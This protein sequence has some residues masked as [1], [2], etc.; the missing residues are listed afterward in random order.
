MAVIDLQR[1]HVGIQSLSSQFANYAA[2]GQGA[3][4]LHTDGYIYCVFA[5][6]Y[7]GGVSNERRLYMTRS[8]DNGLT[9]STEVEISNGYWDDEPAII[10][11]DLSDSSSDIGVVFMRDNTLTRFTFDKDTGADTSP[12]DPITG[13]PTDKKWI[14]VIHIT[15]GYLICCLARSSISS[16]YVYQY[17][18]TDF[19][20]NSWSAASKTVF[21]ANGEPMSLSVKRLSNGHLAMV[22]AYRTALDGRAGVESGYVGMSNLP[23]GMLR[24]DVGAFFSSDDGSTWTSVQ[25]LTNYTGSPAFDLEGILS[26]AAA[27]LQELSDGRIVVGYQEHTSPQYIS[28]ETTLD[29]PSSMNDVSNVIY[30]ESKNALLCGGNDATNGGLFIIDLT[31]QTIT[32]IYNSSTPAIWTNDVV[33]LDLSADGNKLAVAMTTGGICILDISDA[34]PANWTIIKELR[35]TSSPALDVNNV[36]YLKWD[37]STVLYFSYGAFSGYLQWGGRYDTGDDSLVTMHGSYSFNQIASMFV[38]RPDKVVDITTA[39]I[40]AVDKSS[41]SVLYYTLTAATYAAIFYDSVNDEY[42][43]FETGGDLARYKDTGSA[44]SLQQTLDSATTPAWSGLGNTYSWAEIPGYG[45]FARNNHQYCWYSYASQQPAGYRARNYA[46]GLGENV[47]SNQLERGIAVKST[48]WLI[49]PADSLIVIQNLENIGRIRYGY[50]D[51]DSGSKQLITTGVD[52]YDVCNINKVG[53]NMKTLQFPKFCRDAD[54]RL[55]WYFSRWD[56]N[57]PGGNEFAPVLGIVEPDTVKLTAMARIKQIYTQT[58]SGQSRIKQTY[59]ST[60]DARMRIVFAQCIKAKAR[61][62]PRQEQTISMMAQ[63][64]NWKS[65][66]CRASFSVQRTGRTRK[67]RL[68]FWVN[69]GYTK[70]SS[71]TARANII[72]TYTWRATGHFLARVTASNSNLD[73]SVGGNYKQTLDVRARIMKW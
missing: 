64:K 10:Q 42:V 36:T 48:S 61:I 4:L 47:N 65:A 2:A 26:V 6:N 3:M 25:K 60:I 39:R 44:F 24:C 54:D 43:C 63:I 13:S 5:R 59:T 19:T 28:S 27:D 16:P 62:V 29:V 22:G 7:L 72:K 46:L 15:G 37:G 52:F 30:H 73:F 55:Y 70:S 57:Q 12:Y 41:G 9:W 66:M 33:A 67:L 11:L 40:E 32:R 1:Q 71:F 35:T 69:T 31:A 23:A 21:P 20:I 17:T 56:V 51:Y 8:N 68:K 58:V 18:N 50:F 14:S 53:T 49:L 45:V 38:V 34:D